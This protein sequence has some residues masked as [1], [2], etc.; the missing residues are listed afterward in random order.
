MYTLFS[1][2]Q[3]LLEMKDRRQDISL[4]LLLIF[5]FAFFLLFFLGCP[6]FYTEKVAT[7]VNL[8]VFSLP[9]I[10]FFF[11]FNYC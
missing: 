1:S 3:P 9:L 2:H 5:T 4:K 11:F 10:F 8:I 7:Q 6:L